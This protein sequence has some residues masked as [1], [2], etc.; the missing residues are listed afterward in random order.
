MIFSDFLINAELTGVDSLLSRLPHNS[1]KRLSLNVILNPQLWFTLWK[2][3]A[4]ISDSKIN[5]ERRK[6]IFE[7]KIFFLKN[8]GTKKDVFR[9]KKFKARV[10]NQI[11]VQKSFFEKKLHFSITPI[12]FYYLI[13][14]KIGKLIKKPAKLLK[15][16]ILIWQDTSSIPMFYLLAV[17]SDLALRC[18]GLFPPEKFRLTWNML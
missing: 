14:E 1:P 3:F 10:I 9:A 6:N 5:F 13:S 15:T 7:P 2:L 4:K 17:V 12:I 18:F 16:A 8:F 11:L